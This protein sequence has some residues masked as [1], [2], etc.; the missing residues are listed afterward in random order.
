MCLNKFNVKELIY[1]LMRKKLF[2]PTIIV[3][4]NLV[5]HSLQIQNITNED[6]EFIDDEEIVYAPPEEQPKKVE[7]IDDVKQKS[8]FLLK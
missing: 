5:L 3:C 2:F 7:A 1:I 4:L 6:D 8:N